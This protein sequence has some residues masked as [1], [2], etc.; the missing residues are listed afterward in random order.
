MTHAHA[1][2]QGLTVLVGEPGPVR[3]SAL[4][5]ALITAGLHVIGP[6]RD[7]ASLRE[8]LDVFV[9]DAVL[10]NALMLR[11]PAAPALPPLAAGT[12]L[13]V[14]GSP[15]MLAAIPLPPGARRLAGPAT[16][17]AL[18]RNLGRLLAARPRPV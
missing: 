15:A 7:A 4:H 10:V 16:P 3:G 2:L 12:G 14:F 8:M 6:M 18:R 13:L 11:G 9:V 1:G 17:A 5:D